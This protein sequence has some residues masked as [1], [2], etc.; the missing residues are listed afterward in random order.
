MATCSASIPDVSAN[1]VKAV[2]NGWQGKWT[3][4][5]VSFIIYDA[6]TC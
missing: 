1:W 2:L 6:K 5:E 4:H 3:H